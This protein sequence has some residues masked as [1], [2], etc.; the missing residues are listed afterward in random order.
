[1]QLNLSRYLRTRGIQGPWQLQG[2]PQQE[3]QQAVVI[4]ALAERNSL[5]ATLDTL[6]ANPVEL[7]A[8]TL[9]T[10][11]VNQRE[12]APEAVRRDNLATLAELAGY[13]DRSPL[14]LAWIDA[15]SPGCELPNHRGGVG[16]A[17]KLGFDLTLARLAPSP[18]SFIAGL[19]ADT[20]VRPDYLPALADHFAAHPGEAAVIPFCHQPGNDPEHQAAIDRYE[21]FLRH[22]VLGLTLAGSPYAY[23]SIGSALVFSPAAYVKC[24]GM[25]ER[26]AGEDFYLL[27]Q[28]QKTSLVRQLRGTVV[29]PSARPSDRVPFGTGERVGRLLQGDA[30]AVEF[31]AADCFR[32]LATWLQLATGNLGASAQH[33]LAELAATSPEAA[34]YLHGINFGEV[35]QRLQRNHPQAGQ[36]LTA[37]HGWFDA[38]RSMKMIHHLTATAHPRVA[39]E[40]ALKPLLEW[41]G[42][43]TVDK[44]AMQLVLL[45]SRQTGDQAPETSCP[46]LRPFRL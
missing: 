17:R 1:M 30:A 7:L 21:L 28:L 39:P 4:P 10:V 22:Y 12:D 32:I 26:R 24:G 29:Y 2:A 8:A 45:R 18:Q 11:V 9:I 41:A 36:R 6:A 25:N 27:Q 31:Y 38:L 5:F 35:W 42:W 43:P 13:A 3:L 16:L 37:L 34:D 46:S 20:L 40:V 15:A 44:P 19:D 23:H 14:Q 33:L